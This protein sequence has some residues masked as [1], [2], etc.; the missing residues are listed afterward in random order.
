TTLLSGGLTICPTFNCSLDN[1]LLAIN[2]L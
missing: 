2:L 1:G